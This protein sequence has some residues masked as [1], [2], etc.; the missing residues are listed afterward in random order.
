MATGRPGVPTEKVQNQPRLCEV[1]SQ[2]HK[3]KQ[4]KPHKIIKVED[5]KIK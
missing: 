5:E 4:T 3:K 2:E 1:L